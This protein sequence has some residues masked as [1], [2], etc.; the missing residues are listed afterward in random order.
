MAAEYDP[1]TVLEHLTKMHLPD[2][3]SNLTI[4]GCRQSLEEWA[5]RKAQVEAEK[6][7]PKE[8]APRPNWLRP[9]FGRSWPKIR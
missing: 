5:A 9:P 7:A 8:S 3:Q 2:E 4:F 1:S 6:S